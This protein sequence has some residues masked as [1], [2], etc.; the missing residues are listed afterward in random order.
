MN[1]PQATAKAIETLRSTGCRR[2][3]VYIDANT[4][5][6]ISAR[7]APDKRNRLND[8]VLKIGVPNFVE[9]RFIRMCK[10]AGEP[11]PVKKVQI[12][13]WAKKK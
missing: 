8:Y 4:V 3:S 6:A 13:N 7:H 5:V 11:L 10:K 9:R 2:A 12:K 1:I